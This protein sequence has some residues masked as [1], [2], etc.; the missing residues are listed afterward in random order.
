MH[1]TG[2]LS[3]GKSA[4]CKPARTHG[5]IRHCSAKVMFF[6]NLFREMGLLDQIEEPTKVY[7][8]NNTA[9]H[10]VKTGKITDGNQY[11]QMA[12]HQTREWEA[13][14]QICVLAV[15]TKDNFSDLMTKPCGKEEYAL[16]LMV[17]CGYERWVIKVPRETMTFT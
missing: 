8:D 5:I 7:C 17:F 16:F 1:L 2:S 3:A 15:N 6:R 13:D 12:F 4:L 14:G 11:L 9:I 10:W